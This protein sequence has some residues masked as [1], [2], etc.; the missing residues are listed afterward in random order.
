MLSIAKRIRIYDSMSQ[1]LE[2][3]LDL[4]QVLIGLN[5][6]E[7][8]LPLQPAFQGKTLE[9]CLLEHPSIPKTEAVLLAVGTKSSSLPRILKDLS[10]QLA[11][12]QEAQ[13]KLLISTLRPGLLIFILV[14][15][16]PLINFPKTGLS[17]YFAE[18]GLYLLVLLG[19]AGAIAG[20]LRLIWPKRFSIPFLKAYFTNHDFYNF[21]TS[22]GGQL[23]AGVDI[24]QAW[25]SSFK[26]VKHGLLLKFKTL[27]TAS[28]KIGSNPFQH[29]YKEPFN[30]L[31]P[32]FLSMCHSGNISGQLSENLL[33]LAK[34][35]EQRMFAGLRI[36]VV[37]GSTLVMAIVGSVVAYKIITYYTAYFNQID[38]I[39]K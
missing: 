3:G 16:F 32:L 39:L 19:S 4:H 6:P 31:D 8:T 23:G 14:F 17:G 21:T 30:K 34:I 35:Y 5:I 10:S 11:Q 38:E 28:L 1:Q 12:L 24:V 20:G 7:F 22:L 33:K 9:A 37:V 18:V 36:L 26:A 2:A 25:E 15:G 27:G 13:Q 29:L